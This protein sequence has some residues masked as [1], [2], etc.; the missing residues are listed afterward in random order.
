MSRTRTVHGIATLLDQ[1]IHTIRLCFLPPMIWIF[2]MQHLWNLSK[3]V[4]RAMEMSQHYMKFLTLKSSVSYLYQWP[5]G[6]DGVL[7]QKIRR[8]HQPG[9]NSWYFLAIQRYLDKQEEQAKKN[10]VKFK[11][12][13]CKWNRLIDCWNTAWLGRSSAETD[14]MSLWPV[15]WTWA[16]S[17]L[18]QCWRLTASRAISKVL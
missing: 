10:L 5:G 4:N 11:Q 6:R 8:W 3:F 17:V 9:G 15:G 7:S 12:V 16:S 13:R 18:C 14:P 2:R 1:R